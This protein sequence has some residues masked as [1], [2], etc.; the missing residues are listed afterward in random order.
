MFVCYISDVD[1]L[2]YKKKRKKSKEKK[3]NN[4]TIAESVQALRLARVLMV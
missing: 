1:Q 4:V 2:E 3:R